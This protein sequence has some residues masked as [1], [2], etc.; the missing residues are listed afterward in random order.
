MK[1]RSRGFSLIELVV[2]IVIAGIMASMIASF[3]LRPVQ[4][5]V[6]LAQRAAL[7]DQ[8][9]V[10]LR[11]LAR[12]LRRA[13]PNS[14]RVSASGDALEF[15][16]VADAGTYR[17]ARGNNIPLGG[18]GN[19]NSAAE[20]DWLN[21]NGDSRFNILG[22]FH[23]LGSGYPRALPAGT[24]LAIYTT[25][26]VELY[27]DAAS[28]AAT[29]VITP[30]AISVSIQD[31]VDEDALLLSA[32]FDFRYESPAQRVYVVDGPVSYICNNGGLR[33]YGGYAIQTAQPSA[34]SLAGGSLMANQVTGCLFEYQPGTSQRSGL[35]TVRLTLQNGD[36]GAVELLRQIHV[37]NVP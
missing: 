22:R 13:L 17:A 25:D 11:R 35:V 5:S 8:A 36:A 15:L 14:V 7:V 21:F 16:L 10:A 37:G 18:S 6:Q 20:E 27:A 26:P 30:A 32:P 33:R 24:R 4:G 23:D 12:D 28:G 1:S 19:H 2:V 29:G 34:G 9:D 31:D 3:V